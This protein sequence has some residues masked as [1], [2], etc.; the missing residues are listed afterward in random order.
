MAKRM[1]VAIELPAGLAG[2][3]AALDPRIPGLRW[4]PAGQL[5]LT[6][7]F[8][9]DVEEEQETT[10][11][12]ELDK[13]DAP[14]FSLS[15]KGLGSFRRRGRPPVLWAGVEGSLEELL[16]V[17]RK[18]KDA[19]ARVGLEMD[20]KGFRPHVTLGRCKEAKSVALRE[21]LEAHAAREFGEFEVGGFTLCRS[22]LL[23]E[24]AEHLPAFRKVFK[25]GA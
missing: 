19:V 10:L 6:L 5:H 4:L 9:G 15:M 16:L 25:A 23:P 22:V 2:E 3:L 11:V 14:V 13:L 12:A 1:F 21:F 20:G 17:Y 8:L 18:V 24:G 7:A